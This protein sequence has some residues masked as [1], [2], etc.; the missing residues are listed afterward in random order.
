MEPLVRA[1]ESAAA[2]SFTL[3]RKQWQSCIFATEKNIVMLPTYA[4][5]NASTQQTESMHYTESISGSPRSEPT[6]GS[7]NQ[8]R[9]MQM[10][11]QWNEGWP[12]HP[13]WYKCLVDGSEEMNLKFYICQVSR[14]PHWIDKDG[15]YIETQ[16]K[17]K[18]KEA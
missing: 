8:S 4:A 17:V 16:Y 11:G 13:G 3:R 14:K 12:K 1:E 2:G 6:H 18:W 7:R 10:I 9:R 5:M 15:D